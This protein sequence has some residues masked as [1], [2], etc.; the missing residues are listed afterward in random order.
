[1]PQTTNT[2][3]HSR[4]VRVFLSSTFRDM[5]AER[6]Y[7]T[8]YV[9]PRVTEY[10]KSRM[11]EFVPID[12]RWGIPEEDSRNGLV[13]KACLE[14]IDNSRPFFI[15]ILGSRYGWQPTVDELTNLSDM[16]DKDIEWLLDKVA[17]GASITEI[18]MEYAALRNL[19]IPH[20]AFFC[21]DEAVKVADD[22]REEK[23]SDTEHRLEKLKQ[24]IFTQQK[25]AVEQYTS[26]EQLGERIYKLLIDMIESEYPSSGN[27]I[28][29]ALTVPHEASLQRRSVSYC[30]YS[31]LHGY[32]AKWIA[33]N[34]RTLLVLSPAGGGSSTVLANGVMYMRENYNA[35]FLYFDFESLKPGNPMEQLR[36]FMALEQNKPSADVWSLLAIDNAS[37]LNVNELNSL[38]DFIDELPASCHVVMAT[39]LD[40]DVNQFSAFRF[41]SSVITFSSMNPDQARQFVVN[42]AHHYG[43]RLSESQISAI[44]EGTKG[45]TPGEMDIVM[46][47]IVSHGVFETL[48]DRIHSIIK[49]YN[50]SSL[51]WD[52]L[53][54]GEKLFGSIGLIHEYAVI[55]TAIS[56]VTGGI[57]EQDIID[58]LNIDQSRWSVVR[59][60]VMQFCKGSENR[61]SLK[62]SSYI[63][64]IKMTWGTPFRAQVGATLIKWYL[65]DQSRTERGAT[66]IS[67]INEDIWHLPFADKD[68]PGMRYEEYKGLIRDVALSPDMF[69][70]IDNG[71]WIT[72]LQSF[73]RENKF[74]GIKADK[75]YGRRVEELSTQEQVDYYSRMAETFKSFDRPADA[76]WCYDRLADLLASKADRR[77]DI[78]RGLAR[79]AVYDADGAEDVIKKSG[80][81]FKSGFLTM[82]SKSNLS[83]EEL[84]L[85]AAALSVLFEADYLRLK[86]INKTIE[87]FIEVL[88]KVENPHLETFLRERLLKCVTMYSLGMT[89]ANNKEGDDISISLS[90]A[91]E[92]LF[93]DF[94]LSNPG[95]YR[96]LLTR[97]L[98]MLKYGQYE[99]AA[100]WAGMGATS[101]M[102]A[103]GCSFNNVLNTH[104]LSYEYAVIVNMYAVAYFHLKKKYYRPVTKTYSTN[105]Y[106]PIPMERKMT[107]IDFESLSPKV[108]LNL[109]SEKLYYLQWIYSIE[110]DFKKA[111]MASELRALEEKI[112]KLM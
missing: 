70:Y 75:I 104:N 23:G 56:L 52:M 110:P 19:D 32:F 27:D 82:F 66:I 40:S 20:A 64:D 103:Y 55:T 92:E 31:E 87:Q 39:Y 99:N 74:D 57:P 25:Y 37:V 94:G 28:A 60:F 85:K 98:R 24:K 83:Q 95:T 36:E 26:P 69:R 84:K 41:K 7:L 107:G 102:R 73:L 3:S 1:M 22:F 105:F 61:L 81:L 71:R 21:R 51:F 34:K 97:T 59:P 29:D 18:E 77:A 62:K 67:Q 53:N 93:R 106:D 15:G 112:K 8:R 35:P 111:E 72:M 11:L 76:A 13:L 38:L 89:L 96:E 58:A 68:E 80:L 4:Q 49:A 44:L 54:T 47:E 101:A 108:K 30:D 88:D 42:Y 12:L 16:A 78:Y 5:N 45:K 50:S 63:Y 65:A 17:D 9:F 100:Y 109:L 14:E 2:H 86:D 33:D 91:Y 43:K 79:L 46:R 6:D 48:D 90:K 10:C